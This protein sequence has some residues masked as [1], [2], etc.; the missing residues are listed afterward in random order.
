M[1][2]EF[3]EFAD[4]FDVRLVA[5]GTHR[6]RQDPFR[7]VEVRGAVAHVAEHELELGN[8]LGRHAGLLIVLTISRWMGD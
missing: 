3:P 4:A 2:E 1:F 8:L 6:Q 7:P 5:L